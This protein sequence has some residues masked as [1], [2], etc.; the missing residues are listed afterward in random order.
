MWTFLRGLELQICTGPE[1]LLSASYGMLGRKASPGAPAHVPNEDGAVPASKEVF[2]I[3][4]G[5]RVGAMGLFLFVAMGSE[6]S[7]LFR[8]RGQGR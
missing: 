7:W 1:F 8:A 2:G 5:V 3:G 4:G 6:Q